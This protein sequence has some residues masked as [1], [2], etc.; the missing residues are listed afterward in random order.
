[1][2]LKIYYLVEKNVRHQNE[3]I[4]T[5]CVNKNRKNVLYAHININQFRLQFSSRQSIEKMR[6]TTHPDTPPHAYVFIT[7]ASHPHTNYA[8]LNICV[9]IFTNTHSYVFSNMPH[10]NISAHFIFWSIHESISSEQR[11][12]DRYIYNI[13]SANNFYWIWIEHEKKKYEWDYWKKSRY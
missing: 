3:N 6:S 1:M 2:I 4:E 9:H 11:K 8:T 5:Q 12:V 13:Y 7:L 10:R